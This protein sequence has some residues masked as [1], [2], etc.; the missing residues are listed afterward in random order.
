MGDSAK[1]LIQQFDQTFKLGTVA[2]GPGKLRFFGINTIQKEDMTI[3]TDADD[4]LDSLN[5]YSPTRVRRKQSDAPVNDL[6]KSVFVSINSSLGWMG[7]AFSPFCSFY[8]SYLQQKSPN[9]KVCHLTEQQT[10]LR[11][12]KKLGT[13]INYPRPEDKSE[14]QIAL[15]AFA[16]ASKG[17]S[18]GQLGILTGLLVAKLAKDSIFHCTSWLSHKSK[19]PVKSVPAAEI[20]AA[21]EAID[22]VK[23]IAHAY[24]E[25]LDRHIDIHLCVDSKNLFSSRSTQRNSIDRSIRA[26]VACIRYEFQ[27]GNVDEITWIPG[28]LNLADVLTKKDS[29]LSEALQLTLYTGRLTLP[30]EDTLESKSFLKNLG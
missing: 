28:K 2:S 20:L 25:L 21:G 24:S 22:E 8:A 5:E 1:L 10:I 19:R 17:D 27:V 23:S 26:D 4:K 7:G 14:Y 15:L 30:F 13:A 6:E 11:K 18:N 16:D 3:C 12:L 29:M 9:I